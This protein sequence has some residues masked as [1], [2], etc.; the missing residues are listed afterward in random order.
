MVG[1]KL[2]VNRFSKDKCYDDCRNPKK[3]E[4]PIRPRNL[5]FPKLVVGKLNDMMINKKK[6]SVKLLSECQINIYDHKMSADTD[7]VIQQG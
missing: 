1:H 2:Y 7:M 6:V 3:I 4:A 5:T